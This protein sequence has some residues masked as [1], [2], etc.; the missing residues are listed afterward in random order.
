MFLISNNYVPL[1]KT[2]TVIVCVVFLFFLTAVPSQAATVTWDG[3]GGDNNWSTCANWNTTGSPDT[4]P[5]SADAVVFNGT[6]V[7]D[8][9]VDAGFG[10]VVTSVSV[11][12]GYTGVITLARSLQ[13]TTTFSQA[14][15]TFTASNQTLDVDTTFTLSGGSFTASSGTIFLGG[16][17]TISGSPTFNA[18]G[19]NITFDDGTGTLSCN[20]VTFN[21]ITF[22][23]TSTKTISSNCT[24][25]LGSNPTITSAGNLTVNGT[26]SG[27]G[28]L[29]KSAGTI[30]MNAGS[31][32]SGFS[33]MSL[34]IFTVAG[35]TINLS[36]L[37]SFSS[38]ST[39]T[40][41]SGSLLLPSGADINGAFA[42]S[43]G[44]F[45]APTGTITVAGNLT[46][47][48]SPTFNANGGTITFDGGAGN[49]NCN[50][51]TFNNVIINATGSN[52]KA[53]QS[54]CTFPLGNNPTTTKVTVTNSTLSGTGTLT[55]S[56]GG[57]AESIFST[58]SVISGFTGIS[59]QAFTVS[60]GNL[61][62][63]A[64]SSFFSAGTVTL[65]S[66]S[67]ALPSGSD[68]NGALIISG[69]T[70]TA[71][72]GTLTLAGALT[73]SGS[74]I[75]NAN[76]GVFSFDGTSSVTL[77]CNNVIFNIVSFAHTGTA[78]KTVGT[79]CALPLGQDPTVTGR[80]RL[81]AATAALS[82]TGTFTSTCENTSCLRMTS[83]TFTGFS[84]FILYGN[85]LLDGA[86]L[87]LSTYS[88][89]KIY[90][91]VAAQSLSISNNSILTAPA[92]TMQVYE[93]LDLTST[94]TFVH[95]NGTVEFLS[96][97]GNTTIGFT[98]TSV[99]N[100]FFNIVSTLLTPVIFSFPE[101]EVITT[102]GSLTLSGGG[103]DTLLSLRSTTEG[104]SWSIHPN[105]SRSFRYLD[106]KDSTNTH[107]TTASAYCSLDSGNNRNWIFPPCSS[108]I[109]TLVSPTNRSYTNNERTTFTWHP[110]SSTSEFFQAVQEYTL[111]LSS[112]S[113][114]DF[115]VEGIP[116]QPANGSR[117][118]TERYIVDYFNWDDND[119]ANN[120]IS[121]TTKSSISWP[122]DQHD[123]R[124][125]EGKRNWKVTLVDTSGTTYEQSYELFVDFTTPI[126]VITQIN[127]AKY[128]QAMVTTDT[129]PTLYGRI[130][131]RLAGQPTGEEVA[132][133]PR[134]F[135]ILIE[136]RD[137]KNTY[138]VVL[139]QIIQ[140]TDQYWETDAQRINDNT[141]NRS[142]KYSPFEFTTQP[143]AYG[144]YRITLQGRDG[145]DNS[146]NHEVFQ[147]RI[148][149][150]EVLESGVSENETTMEDTEGEIYLQE[151]HATESAKNNEGPSKSSLSL[152]KVCLSIVGVIFFILLLFWWKF[153]S[154][155]PRTDDIVEV[156]SK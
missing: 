111:T 35:G 33:G 82:G 70:F 46:I 56:G 17:L 29:T 108:S 149:R 34:N 38:A 96:E 61:D 122:A 102:L 116:A 58:G 113:G 77:T 28:T 76:G 7:K 131:D 129:T 36:G 117:R 118:E 112:S 90:G 5:T 62:F 101:G 155:R 74:P 153:R 19:G 119:L 72:S 60:G 3:G 42:I 86:N 137:A 66:G 65:S 2:L 110:P 14:T 95:N 79:G 39:L 143:L 142:N 21:L 57:S 123:G 109:F 141:I 145:A 75:F 97:S 156:N 51:V 98:S 59:T 106:V 6:S 128:A 25:P 44:S 30:T 140:L 146:Y 120:L 133:G 4:C 151:R 15:G 73:I 124:I 16:A 99:S 53:L 139:S 43:G 132:S 81:N 152:T 20:N 31:G 100:T 45:T 27:S 138:S 135:S 71:P 105:G 13:T 26:L 40:L 115:V 67:L 41:S 80:I 84:G 50:N 93:L 107:S 148:Q 147:I 8:A 22:T 104:S 12:A 10:G 54:N 134:E 55:L 88:T 121:L 69:G 136:K 64:Y 32:F 150:S 91:R 85:L 1:R 52:I 144:I 23:N 130:T 154:H 83:G 127:A 18:N 63:S 11:N 87:D 47:T 92:G 103:S 89:V 24:L 125:T 48:N 49:L 68:L 9:T 114:N 94:G 37:S 78:T 126:T